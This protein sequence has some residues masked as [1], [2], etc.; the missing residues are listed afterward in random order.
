MTEQWQ[1]IE[2][3][4][5]YQISTNGRIVRNDGFEPKQHVDTKSNGYKCLRVSLHQNNRTVSRLLAQAFIGDTT[6]MHV[7]HIDA[8]PSNNHL[9]NLEIITPS[10]HSSHHNTGVS[11]PNV[12][13][14]EVQVREIYRLATTSELA[15]TEIGNM[16][17]VSLDVVSGICT[18]RSWKHL[19]LPY[20]SRSYSGGAGSPTRSLV[21]ADVYE[22]YRLA[23]TTNMSQNAIG[24]MFGVARNTVSDIC[25]GKKWKH[26]NLPYYSRR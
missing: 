3:F 6:G 16:F 5:N 25:H 20:Y 8:N 26:L 15:Q 22:I 7:H 13:L 10:E 9:S 21:E 17:G 12:K 14:T 2:E 18:G 19:N 1:V 23:T 24:D 4:P 11:H